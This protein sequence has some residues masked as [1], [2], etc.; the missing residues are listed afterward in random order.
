MRIYLIRKN[1][2]IDL[3]KPVSKSLL[4]KKEITVNKN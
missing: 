4:V 1:K 2:F 3:L